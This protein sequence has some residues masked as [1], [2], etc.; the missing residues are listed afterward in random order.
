MSF[1]GLVTHV[2]RHVV[3]YLALFL[4]LGGVGHAAI[5]GPNGTIKACVIPTTGSDVPNTRIIDSAASC[6]GGTTL[7]WNQTGPTGATGQTGAAG[8]AGPA[9]PVGPVGPAGAAGAAGETTGGAYMMSKPPAELARKPGQRKL[10][11]K[12][13]RASVGPATDTGGPRNVVVS[14]RV[15]VTGLS[16]PVTFN[17]DFSMFNNRSGRAKTARIE[18]PA[19]APDLVSLVGEGTAGT[20]DPDWEVTS[21]QYQ[22]GGV[23]HA[24]MSV[25]DLISDGEPVPEDTDGDGDLDYVPNPFELF[26]FDTYKFQLRG[27]CSS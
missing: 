25:I 7:T 21:G 10:E 3:G 5:V 24:W 13:I 16:G 27:E 17:V 9:G 22:Q 2:R 19:S 11:I 18:C 12:R 6:D 20:F 4:V 8:Q 26:A 15:F 23:S 14:R 1:H